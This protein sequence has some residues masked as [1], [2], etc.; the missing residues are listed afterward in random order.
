MLRNCISSFVYFFSVGIPVLKI[1]LSD[2]H[3][4]VTSGVILS[5]TIFSLVMSSP[6]RSFR[7]GEWV[8]ITPKCIAA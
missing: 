3:E 5:K 8:N 6:G 4:W 1:V 7:H 2:D